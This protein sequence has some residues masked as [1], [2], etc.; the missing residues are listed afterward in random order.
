M[1]NGTSRVLSLPG[2]ASGVYYI[3][4]KTG[5]ETIKGKIVKF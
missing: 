2:R 1:E 5:S 3:R 4:V